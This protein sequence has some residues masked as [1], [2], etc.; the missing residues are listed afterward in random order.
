MKQSAIL[1]SFLVFALTVF[2][3]VSYKN[4]QW[5]LSSLSSFSGS[6]EGLFPHKSNSNY[7]IPSEFETFSNENIP[8]PF[9]EPSAPAHSPDPSQLTGSA[10]NQEQPT[11]NNANTLGN[12]FSDFDSSSAFEN[13][14]NNSDDSSTPLTESFD[15]SRQQTPSVPPFF[16]GYNGGSDSEVDGDSSKMDFLGKPGLGGST[17]QD[18]NPEAFNGPFW[19]G[20]EPN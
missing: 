11:L 13:A 9:G 20:S 3:W 7:P 16:D 18:E 2:G 4:G 14:F 19:G 10:K 8:N 15:S 1:T 17:G 5:F 12:D 6:F